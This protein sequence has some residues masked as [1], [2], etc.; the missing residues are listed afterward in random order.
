M[1]VKA[2][3]CIFGFC[4]IEH[5]SASLLYS[6]DHNSRAF[7]GVSGGLW[8]KC[9]GKETEP[10]AGANDQA[11]LTSRAVN[12]E[13]TVLNDRPRRGKNKGAA[14]RGAAFVTARSAFTPAYKRKCTSNFKS[15]FLRRGLTLQPQSTAACFRF[16]NQEQVQDAAGSGF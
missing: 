3:V 2:P 9:K 1:E 10:C 13:Q 12:V 4:S 8:Y 7:S 11:G 15:P 6:I 5:S 16:P 14:H